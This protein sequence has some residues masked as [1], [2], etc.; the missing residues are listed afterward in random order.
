MTDLDGGTGSVRLPGRDRRAPAA[1]RSAS[2]CRTPTGAEVARATGGD[3]A[4]AVPDARARGGRA[5]ATS[6][7]WPSSCRATA[8]RRRPLRAADRHPDR[9][10]S[11]ARA[12]S[13]TA[14]PSTSA[15][16]ASTRT[17][18]VRGKGHDDAVH[19]A[20]LR[21]AGRGSGA[22]SFRTSHYP[23]AEE[24]LEYADRRGIVVIDETPAVGLNIGPGRRHLRQP[25]VH[26][27]LRGH[28]QRRDAGGPP[29]GDPR[30]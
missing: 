8:T 27:L 19:G 23:Y 14:S 29:P 7:T 3:G 25:G 17:A 30:S 2:R 21:A 16:S 6:T 10:R 28:H 15:G 12:S 18:H 9:A 4:L 22:N 24:V 13:S 26:D 11:T 1:C 5:R 20:R